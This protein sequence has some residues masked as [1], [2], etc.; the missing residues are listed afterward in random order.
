MASSGDASW[1]I[2]FAFLS[3]LACARAI[4]YR[5]FENLRD[6]VDEAGAHIIASS[7]TVAY[8]MLSVKYGQ[9]EHVLFSIG[10]LVAMFIYHMFA[11]SERGRVARRGCTSPL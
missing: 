11:H 8:I 7:M 9:M 4:T 1:L 10:L 2:L 5:Y 3:V 6:L